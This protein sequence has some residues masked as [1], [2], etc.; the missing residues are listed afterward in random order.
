MEKIPPLQTFL[1]KPK[2]PVIIDLDGVVV[3]GRSAIT[4]A[5]RIATASNLKEKRYYAFDSTGEGWSFNPEHW[6]LSPFCEK[7]RW[8]KLE[9]IR[10]CNNRKNKASD[11]KLYSEKSLSA[12]R[13]DRIFGDIFE[14]INK[15]Q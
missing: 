7:R 1:R 5:R 4:L 13:V 8:T 9:I 12:K 14:L 15:T 3:C 11:E 2:Y 6:A 10:L